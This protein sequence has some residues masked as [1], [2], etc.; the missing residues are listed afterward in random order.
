MRGDHIIIVKINRKSRGDEDF[1]YQSYEIELKEPTSILM[2]LQK[3]F[4]NIDSSL[5]FYD[6]CGTGKCKGCHL[7]VDGVVELACT[8]IITPAQRE[9]LLEPSRPDNVITD[10]LTE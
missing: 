7:K 4:W 5:A 9:I 8:K 2:I 3:I 1:T 6:G 10:L